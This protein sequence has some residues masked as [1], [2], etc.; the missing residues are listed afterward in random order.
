M[1][2]IVF[3]LEKFRS[4]LIGSRVTIFT[5]H[6]AIK[7]LLAKTDPKSGLIR[8]VLLLQEFDI[9][10]KDKKG[11]QNVVADHLSRLKNK[12]VTKEKPEVKGEFPDE[13]LLQ[14]T[15]RP[16]FANMA[17][18][19]AMRVIP[20][21]LNWSQSKKFLHD[22]RFYVWDDPHLFKAGADNLLRRCV[23]KE[24]A[25]SI[26]WH[27]HSSPY[28]GHHSGDR[29]T[30]KVLQSNFMGPLPS[31]YGNVYILVAVDYVSKW[32]EAIATPK[33]DARVVI[34]FL[35]KNIFSHFG[36]LQALISDGGTHFC[37]NQLKKDLEHYNVQHK[38]A[39]PYH[40]QTNG[41]VE[42]SNRELKIAFKT[43]IGLSPFQLVYGKACHLPVELEHKAY[44]ALKLLNFD[45]NA[46]GEKRK[47]QL[48]EL[49]EM[50]LNAYESSRIY[51]QKKKAYHDRKLQRK[52]FQPGQQLLLFNSRLR[53]FPGKLKSKW[54]GPFIIKEVRPHGAVELV[55]PREENFEKKWIINGQRL[56]PYNGGQLERLTTI[57]YL[58]D[59]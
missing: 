29:T 3:A 35:K 17:N 40:P 45:N 48:L 25:Q 53:L 32:V 56:K 41:H 33:D 36:V 57:I 19:K 4:Y 13:F 50:R 26:L 12:D 39:T 49:E 5:D 51:K 58:N 38:V 21:E 54:S 46:C 42:I 22:A 7:H 18:Y 34:K 27:C 47:L 14:V 30:A 55:D 16:W 1:L 10:I 24:E 6:A 9:I 23:T 59:P 8:W 28:G 2:A 52:E 11:F 20:E 31:S 43:P 37:N 44:W 15:A